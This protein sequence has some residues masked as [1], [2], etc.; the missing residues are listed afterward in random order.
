VIVTERRDHGVP[1]P[2]GVPRA[3]A[4]L[5]T[6]L[7]KLLVAGYAT[8]RTLLRS[9]ALARRGRDEHRTTPIAMVERTTAWGRYFNSRI[10]MLRSFSVPG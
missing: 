8:G 5:H 10:R 6:S 4:F 9:A 1:D 7:E 2:P 3:A